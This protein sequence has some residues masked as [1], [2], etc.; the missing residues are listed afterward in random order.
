MGLYFG[1][2]DLLGGGGGGIGK[3]VTVGDYSYP[4]AQDID[5]WAKEKYMTWSTERR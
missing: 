2:N 4:N 5:F 3:T 1:T